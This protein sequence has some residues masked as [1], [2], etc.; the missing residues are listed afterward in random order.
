[1]KRT[2]FA[3]LACDAKKERTRRQHFLGER[4]P[5]GAVA[6]RAGIALPEPR[7][8]SPAAGAGADVAYLLPAAVV[9][10]VRP[11]SRAANRCGALPALTGGGPP[12]PAERTIIRFR[13][14]LKQQRLTEQLFAKVPLCWK[15]M[16]AVEE[17]HH[18]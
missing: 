2:T 15:E 16:L 11:A 12:L 18:C 1:M 5:V 3:S 4:S 7:Q 8:R 10:C 6:G 13:H 17:R 9:Q 14:L